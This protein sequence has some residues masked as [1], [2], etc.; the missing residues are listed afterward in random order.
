MEGDEKEDDMSPHIQHDQ[1]R[2]RSYD[3]VSIIST[4]L[5]LP[6]D[7]SSGPTTCASIDPFLGQSDEPVNHDGSPGFT[8]H[9]A[10]THM[11]EST[12]LSAVN[13]SIKL[14]Y[15][16]GWLA[17]TLLVTSPI[18]A[19]TLIE[20]LVFIWFSNTGNKNWHYLMV[21]QWATR[22]VSISAMII[23]FVTDL[24][25]G[26]GASMLA[27][28]SLEAFAVQLC[29]AAS[30][31]VMRSGLAT[32]WRLII[33]LFSGSQG[34]GSLPR[35]LY[36]PLT[37]VL[38][39]TTILLQFSSTLLLSDLRLGV[40]QGYSSN[41]TFHYDFSYNVNVFVGS[42]K[43]WSLF[44]STSAPLIHRGTTWLR[45]PPFYP[46]FAEYS[47]LL[48]KLGEVDDTGYLF[49][50]FLPFT[51][52]QS[53]QTIRNFTG[54]AFVVD[55]RVSCQK[56]NMK[57]VNI[58]INFNNKTLDKS[59]SMIGTV[60]G[61]LS[62]STYV[63]D[64]WAPKQP[65]SFECQYLVGIAS[66]AICQIQGPQYMIW[67]QDFSFPGLGDRLAS[68]PGESAGSL[69]SKLT[70]VTTADMEP[71]PFG[72]LPSWGPTYLIIRSYDEPT[73]SALKNESD[74]VTGAGENASPQLMPTDTEWLQ[75]SMSLNVTD[76]DAVTR[77][78]NH[79]LN[80]SLCYTSWQTANLN[81]HMFSSN[82]DMRN[83]AQV[84]FQNLSLDAVNSTGFQAPYSFAEVRGQMGLLSQV[85]TPE[86]R[87]ILEL[88]N[89]S[90][91]SIPD[92]AYPIQQQ[93]PVQAFADMS[94]L[95]LR[96]TMPHEL[97]LAHW[98]NNSTTNSSVVIDPDLSYFESSR[99]AG[100][101]TAVLADSSLGLVF[102]SNINNATLPDPALSSFFIEA[103]GT[104]GSIAST[105]SSLLTIL[106]GMAYYD[107]FPAYTKTGNATLVFFTNV[108]YPQSY[109]GF[110]AVVILVLI[111]VLIYT[112]IT[113]LFVWRTKFTLLGNDWTAVAQVSA[114]E[115]EEILRASTLITDK[116][117][118]INLGDKGRKHIRVGIGMHD[119]GERLGI[120]TLRWREN[121]FHAESP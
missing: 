74:V 31:S 27:A 82:E 85:T 50:A 106:S 48:P 24:L 36:L 11:T 96:N 69:R 90:W 25:A 58:I 51:D 66:F 87:G 89:Q 94:G 14:R 95:G 1:R 113:T 4:I 34:V 79:A 44:Q 59:E 76:S 70:N 30:V 93:P 39:C 120:T 102:G 111:Q 88:S 40:L 33:P 118:N 108:L 32:P 71:K 75:M 54:P 103:M 43:G 61:T 73:L 9:T 29:D 77:M 62:N 47:E 57:N 109:R 3:D 65:I 105:M 18:V 22:A 35:Y 78:F 98:F 72:T 56:P 15:K 49:R 86:Q 97:A 2:R 68:V 45:N 13:L 91:V 46:T 101:W 99:L 60:T 81:V 10:T 28:L 8:Y 19:L 23:R 115:T 16:L 17:I 6:A 53:R 52:A 20:I 26:T 112:I 116:E 100:N 114:P 7:Q 38:A 119:D 80:V 117:V 12:Q 83:E 37:V 5:T 104:N 63:H 41:R 67:D 107:Q 84:R 92:D 42:V 121:G 21:N 110:A 55:S 64:L